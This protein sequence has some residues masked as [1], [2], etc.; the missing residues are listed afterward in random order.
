MAVAAGAKV[1]TLAPGLNDRTRL[2]TSRNCQGGNLGAGGVRERMRYYVTLLLTVFCLASAQ[3]VE[4]PNGHNSAVYPSLTLQGLEDLQLGARVPAASAFPGL[5]WKT[6]AAQPWEEG[7]TLKLY[8]R[9]FYLGRGM[10]DR[11]G[12]LVELEITDWRV[13]FDNG[14][15][16]AASTWGHLQKQLTDVNLNYAYELDAVVAESPDLPGLQAHFSPEVYKVQSRLEGDFTP[17]LLNELPVG[18]KVAKLRLF[19]VPND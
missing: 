6:F 2:W 15:F 9:G 7:A 4:Q 11:D 19:W 5:T 1:G 17:L 16:A 3:A 12:R 14:R 8:H 10:L 18:A 13:T